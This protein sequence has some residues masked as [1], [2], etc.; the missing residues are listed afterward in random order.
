M[1]VTQLLLKLCYGGFYKRF[2]SPILRTAADVYHE[3]LYQ[4][5]TVSAVCHLRVELYTVSFGSFDMIGRYANFICTSNNLEVVWNFLDSIP[6][7]HPHLR[8]CRDALQQ[9]IRIVHKLQVCPTVFT[10]F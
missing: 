1:V 5:L 8:L 2:R 10:N 3:I 4:N 6:A 7:R 9:L